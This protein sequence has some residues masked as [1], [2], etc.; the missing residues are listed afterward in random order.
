MNRR[1]FLKT[2][3]AAYPAAILLGSAAGR[4]ASDVVELGP[5]KIRVSRLALGMG[6]KGG[7]VQRE[8]GIDGAAD[9]LQ[10]GY[11]RGFS[12]G[13]PPTPTKPTPTSRPV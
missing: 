1:N 8:L 4:K 12:T 6:T 11:D 3:L 5:R 9:M 10:F 7:N 2:T 13:K